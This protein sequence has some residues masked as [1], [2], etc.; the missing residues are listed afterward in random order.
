MERRTSFVTFQALDKSKLR[1]ALR[2][3][4]RALSKK[5]INDASQRM[6]QLF[7][8]QDFFQQAKT[9]AY[10]LPFHGE[11]DPTPLLQPW[12]SQTDKI[13]CLPRMNDQ[14]HKHLSFYIT[15]NREQLTPH[16]TGILQPNPE[17]TQPITCEQIDLL[18]APLVAFD[19]AGNR[20]GQGM[21]YY[22]RTLANKDTEPQSYP[23][24]VGIAYSWQQVDH[25]PQESW[26]IPL[27]WVITDQEV[28]KLQP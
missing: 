9:I 11:I 15:N 20:L 13:L 16:S 7:A 4:R 6:A 14:P 21:G 17:T 8:K 5:E 3:K 28:F 2:A 12:E 25:L 10:Y 1:T 19:N 18:I 24:Y 26:D 27:D 23:R 22:D